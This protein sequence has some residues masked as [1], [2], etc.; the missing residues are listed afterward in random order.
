MKI[1]N[2]DIKDTKGIAKVVVDTWRSTY[3]GIIPNDY[4]ENMSY[5]KAEERFRNIIN[6]GDQI[7]LVVEDKEED[8]IGFASGGEERNGYNICEGEIY[9]LY[10][11]KE[12]QNIGIGKSLVKKFI[13]KLIEKEIKSIII[14]VLAENSSKYFYKAL[15]GKKFKEKIC[16]IG[17]RELKEIGYYWNDLKNCIE[18]WD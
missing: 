8:I 2:A 3:K 11:L 12:Y 18:T 4:L 1:R 14:W 7:V 9:A 15:G 6:K 10:V 5:K 17:G 16:N 13:K